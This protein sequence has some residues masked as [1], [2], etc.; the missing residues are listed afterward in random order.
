MCFIQKRT[1]ENSLV[2]FTPT[3]H[4]FQDKE[5]ERIREIQRKS[6]ERENNQSYYCRMTSRY[7]LQ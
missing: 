5:L 2:I 6:Q 3:P 1:K 7:F 4:I